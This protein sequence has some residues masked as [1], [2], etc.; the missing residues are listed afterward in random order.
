[1]VV[2][3][4][5]VSSPPGKKRVL[6]LCTANSCRSQLAEAL[7]RHEAGDRY[8]VFSAGTEPKEIH[9]LTA[10]V[11]QEL[12]ISLKGHRSKDVREFTGQHFD[13]VV[14]VCGHARDTCPAFPRAVRMEHWPIDNP[15]ATVGSEEAVL[16][17]FRRV[18]DDIRQRI[19]EYVAPRA[20]GLTPADG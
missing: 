13:L 15:A 9:P 20:A 3:K 8:D 14:T 1:M 18:R 6:I 16:A 4:P 11:L 10:R 7:W 19:R 12:S 2:E 17:V 5:I